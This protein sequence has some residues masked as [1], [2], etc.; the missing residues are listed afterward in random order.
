[1]ASKVSPTLGLPEGE[2][3]PVACFA[4]VKPSD[5]NEGG[6]A[7]AKRLTSWDENA[8]TVSMSVE[9]SAEAKIF[10][11]LAATLPPDVAQA[12]V[13]EVVAAPLVRRW[14][15]GFDV[16][17]ISYGQTGSGKT[18]TMF[19][20][21]QSMAIAAAA[22]GADGGSGGKGIVQE[23]HG[24]IIR[25][26]MAALEELER[27]SAF[28]RN[29][30]LFGS[31]VE[32]SILTFQDQ[33]ACDLINGRKPYFVDADHHL[34]GAAQ[35]PLR[36]ALD[37]VRMAAAVE[38]R[39]VRGTKMND[40]SSRSHCVAIFTLMVVDPNEGG[41]GGQ[42]RTSRLQFFDLM[43]S[44][45]FKGG[46]AA[47]DA[48][49]SSK[50]Q[51]AS[52]W[53][54]IYANLSLSTLMAAVESSAKNRLKK[55]GGG[56]KSKPGNEM[57]N[58]LLTS[59]LMGSLTGSALTG[60]VTCVSQ[61]PRNGAETF[62]SLKYS[63]GMAKLMNQPQPQPAVG[64]ALE[65]NRAKKRLDASAAIM[66][67]GV[68]GKYQARREAEVAQAAHDVSAIEALAGGGSGP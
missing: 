28:G 64:L 4:R 51:G 29:A 38:T 16:D 27:L 52:G 30:V 24:F 20:P 63:A 43:G 34:Q 14:L 46:N 9:G 36:N 13:Y 61:A 62:L 12:H 44:E 22:L 60:M 21:P 18:F 55:K 17:L 33:T 5:G 15:D 45:R 58:F 3:Q 42:L 26:G 37:V 7:A 41:G 49:K 32:L 68:Q 66:R 47:H 53:E 39:L 35:V 31:M 8:G 19:G 65:L 23:E 25:S 40:T 54:G 10:D 48:S 57:I 6:V 50:G 11:H 59:L 56:G 1:M 67:R 2:L